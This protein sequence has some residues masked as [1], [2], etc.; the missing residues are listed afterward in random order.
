LSSF[1]GASCAAN[2]L[3]CCCRRLDSRLVP[4]RDF[5]SKLAA[6]YDEIRTK[7]FDQLMPVVDPV[8]VKETLAVGRFVILQGGKRRRR[9]LNIPNLI[10]YNL[11]HTDEINRADLSKILGEAILSLVIV[12]RVGTHSVVALNNR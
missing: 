7:W 2:G 10:F 1:L 11:L 6:D 5:I 8:H 12:Y 9:P 4:G 3:C